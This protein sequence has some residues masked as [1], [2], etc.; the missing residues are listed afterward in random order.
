[1]A[2]MQAVQ[3]AA[4]VENSVAVVKS[5]MDMV[6][7]RQPGRGGDMRWGCG[8]GK[9]TEGLHVRLPLMWATKAPEATVIG[10][11]KAKISL[12]RGRQERRARGA[13]CGGWKQR[14]DL[15]RWLPRAPALAAAMAEV[16]GA[17]EAEE[18][19]AAVV[20]A[21]VYLVLRKHKG[22]RQCI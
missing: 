9:Q 6:W 20:R 10:V 12:V 16:E 1:M 21:R 4:T 14:G 7:E 13:G 19:V 3:K 22:G 18:T 15:R 2:V 5:A 8:S 17:E 11:V